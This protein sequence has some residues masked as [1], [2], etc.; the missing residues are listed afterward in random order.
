MQP[1]VGSEA[2]LYARIAYSGITAIAPEHAKPDGN[3]PTGV[4]SGGSEGRL[5]GSFRANIVLGNVGP[6]DA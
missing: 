2:R 4:G 5:L 6:P 3:G 1:Q